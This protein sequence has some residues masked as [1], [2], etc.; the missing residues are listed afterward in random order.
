MNKSERREKMPQCAAFIDDMVAVFGR[1]ARIVA[2]E[3]GHAVRL[4]DKSA[5]WAELISGDGVVPCLAPVV[6]KK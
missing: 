4:L 2:S 3:N 6:K 5:P 1:P